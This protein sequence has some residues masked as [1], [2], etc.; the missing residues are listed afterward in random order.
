MQILVERQPGRDGEENERKDLS[1]CATI[2]ADDE[3]RGHRPHREALSGRR[4]D[5]V[6]EQPNG[7][8]SDN[9]RFGPRSYANMGLEIKIIWS[10]LR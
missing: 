8:Q 7:W 4:D 6:D 1:L 10:K 3:R 2:D 9:V 5:F